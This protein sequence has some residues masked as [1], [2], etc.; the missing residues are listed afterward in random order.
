MHERLANVNGIELVYD[1]FGAPHDPA[2]LMVMGLGAQMIWWEEEF[3]ELLAASGFRVVR[4]DNRD[5]G[6][7]SKIEGGPGPNLAAAIAGDGSSASYTLSD[8]AADAVGL[9]DVL[10]IGAAHV[11]GASMGGMI[12]QTIAIE[13]PD[14]VLSLTSIMSTTGALEVGRP[15]PDGMAALAS[16]PPRGDREAYADWGVQARRII[17]SPGYPTDEADLRRRVLRSYDRS[18]Y[19]EGFARQL[20]AIVASGDR[21]ERLGS[22]SVPTLVIHGADDPL[23]DVSGGEATAGAIPDAR[24][25][26][27]PGMGHDIPRALWPKIVDAIVE[28]AARAAAPAA[29]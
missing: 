21:T 8:M 23:I 13:Y 10:E 12:A 27:I 25:V 5:V 28:N 11:V 20:V 18:F 22:V 17:G 4:F 6:N 3:C 9:L 26:V 19:P 7:S 14:R 16:T 24:L 15:H 1:E 29:G 2:M